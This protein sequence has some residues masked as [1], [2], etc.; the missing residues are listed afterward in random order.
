V[1]HVEANIKAPAAII[2]KL[3]K[4]ED[5]LSECQVELEALLG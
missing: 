5:E 1:E 4:F 2:A 3:H